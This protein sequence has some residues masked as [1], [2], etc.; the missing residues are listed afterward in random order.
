[1]GGE[2]AIASHGAGTAITARLPLGR[3]SAAPVRGRPRMV[4]T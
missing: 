4:G 2:F 3:A 1:M